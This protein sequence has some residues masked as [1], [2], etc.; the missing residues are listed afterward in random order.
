MAGAAGHGLPAPF[1]GSQPAGCMLPLFPL[2]RIPRPSLSGVQNAAKMT[3]PSS[4]KIRAERPG[5]MH[6]VRNA[7]KKRERYS[8]KSLTMQNLNDSISIT[9]AR[10]QK[11]G[12]MRSWGT[13]APIQAVDG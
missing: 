10:K 9:L 6:I 7:A 11:R 1:G 4:T 3:H 13:S 5:W 8:A 12:R 2:V